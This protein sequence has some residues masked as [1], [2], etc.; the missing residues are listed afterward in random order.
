MLVIFIG[1]ICI[2]PRFVDGR[3]LCHF[4]F[5]FAA[6]SL[7]HYFARPFRSP[8]QTELSFLFWRYILKLKILKKILK[9]YKSKD[10]YVKKGI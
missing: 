2:I 9:N 8:A 1:G 7:E 4:L 3:L 10:R 6:L 5:P